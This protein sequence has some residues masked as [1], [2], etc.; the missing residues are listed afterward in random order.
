MAEKDFITSDEAKILIAEAKETIMRE[1]MEDRGD[2]KVNS[3]GITELRSTV[4]E[5]KEMVN[6]I[7]AFQKATLVSVVLLGGAGILTFIL[8]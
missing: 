4:K 8:S 2:I 1:V 5:I 7:S 3:S 6:S